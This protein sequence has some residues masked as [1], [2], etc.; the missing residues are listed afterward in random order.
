MI[1]LC[2][3]GIE[4]LFY[5]ILCIFIWVWW[6]WWWWLILTMVVVVDDFDSGFVDFGCNG[7][8]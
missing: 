6:L 5:F 7:G 4:F 3:A 1:V 8:G 2:C